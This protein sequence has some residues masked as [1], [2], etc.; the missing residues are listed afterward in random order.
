MMEWI[1]HM[2][3][4]EANLNEASFCLGGKDM[5]HVVNLTLYNVFRLIISSIYLK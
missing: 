5:L 3:L 2:Y 4:I 1:S